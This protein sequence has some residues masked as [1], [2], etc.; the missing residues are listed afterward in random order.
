MKMKDEREKPRE[1]LG[2]P[3]L[4]KSM[5]TYNS[6]SSRSHVTLNVINERTHLQHVC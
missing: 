5:S 2:I 6:H 1:T 4:A 3:W